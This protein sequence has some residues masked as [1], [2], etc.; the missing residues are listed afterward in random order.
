MIVVG[1]EFFL[2]RI[3]DLQICAW[4]KQTPIES[5]RVSS[6]I[7]VHQDVLQFDRRIP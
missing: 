6:W 7:N 5:E 4:L 1:C 3:I 2:A